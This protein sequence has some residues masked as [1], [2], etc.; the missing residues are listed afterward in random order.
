MDVPPKNL[1]RLFLIDAYALIYR[2]FF[3]FI[4][5]PLT[6]SKGENTSAPFG[7][8]NFLVEIRDKYQPDY[9]AVVF[10]AGNSDREKVYPGVQGQPGR[11]CPMSSGPVCPACASSWRGSTTPSSN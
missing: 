9:L 10:D 2:A 1:P 6:N 3:A 11:R 4:N 8:A 7:F 5:R